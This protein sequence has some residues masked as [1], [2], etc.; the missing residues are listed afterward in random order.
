MAEP[1]AVLH[2]EKREQGLDR[3]VSILEH[4]PDQGL[5]VGLS[6]LSVGEG[7]PVERP[8]SPVPDLLEKARKRPWAPSIGARDSW[9]HPLHRGGIPDGLLFGHTDVA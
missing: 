5:A 4:G 7:Q 6:E 2:R 8:L 1:R 3:V 9:A